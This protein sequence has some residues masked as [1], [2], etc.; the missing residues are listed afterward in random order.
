MINSTNEENLVCF[1]NI[2]TSPQ[3]LSLA[4]IDLNNYE[5]SSIGSNSVEANDIKG[6]KSVVSQNK[7]KAL[8]CL[9]FASDKSRCIIYS[10]IDSFYQYNEYDASCSAE[11][12]SLNLEY[13][14]E[15]EQYILS[16]TDISGQ[17]SA[18]IFDKEF[19]NLNSFSVIQG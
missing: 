17:I 7:K 8:I 13:I 10:F 4:T 18:A 11:L 6:I 1:F 15:T 16:C 5:V 12:C 2:Q 9:N 3:I 19:N 14:R